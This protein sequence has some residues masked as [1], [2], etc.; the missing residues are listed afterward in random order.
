MNY[1]NKLPQKWN[2]REFHQWKRDVGTRLRKA[3][4]VEYGERQMFQ[5]AKDVGISQ[6]SLSEIVNGISLPCAHTL[7]KITENTTISVQYL[8]KG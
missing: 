3:I 4:E 1:K 6:G 5:F 2:E 8:L 7:F